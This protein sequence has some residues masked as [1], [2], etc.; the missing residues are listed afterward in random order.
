MQKSFLTKQPRTP[1]STSSSWHTTATGW[2]QTQFTATS[3]WRL[4][5]AQMV[6]CSRVRI[7]YKEPVIRTDC[8]G[9]N[10]ILTDRYGCSVTA[11]DVKIKHVFH[12]CAT[13][14]I[15]IRT[16]LFLPQRGNLHFGISNFA[17][18]WATH[19]YKAFFQQQTKEH[20][21]A[22]ITLYFQE[23]AHNA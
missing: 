6:N 16:T 8:E 18:C 9:Q 20:T 21:L 23:G 2:L 22:S 4:E 10:W 13:F 7:N 15:R 17:L 19:L 5:N 14:R 3:K 11:V 12:F 1:P